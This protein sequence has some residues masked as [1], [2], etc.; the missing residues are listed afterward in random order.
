MVTKPTISGVATADPSSRIPSRRRAGGP[1][2]NSM[3]VLVDAC[4][5]QLKHRRSSSDIPAHRV[6][7]QPVL[8]STSERRHIPQALLRDYFG[9]LVLRFPNASESAR[10][11]DGTFYVHDGVH[12]SLVLAI[13]LLDRSLPFR[14]VRASIVQ[15]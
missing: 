14:E 8:P 11:P 2:R 13:G 10:S 1:A 9:E 15:P 5:R 6:A 12:R 3:N 7:W 4:W